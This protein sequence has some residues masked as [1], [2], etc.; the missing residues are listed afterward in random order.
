MN[1]G[2]QD[3]PD[4]TKEHHLSTYSIETED[5][6]AVHPDKDAD[7]REAGATGAAFATEEQLSEATTLW[8]DSSLVG[9]WNSFAGAPPF[10]ELKE[11]RR[12]RD[13]K[14]VVTKI[15]TAAQRPG[16]ALQEEMESVEV[17]MLRAQQGTLNPQKAAKPAKAAP[18]APA[19]PRATKNSTSRTAGMYPS[20]ARERARPQCSGFSSAT[21][22]PRRKRSWLRP[23][24]RQKLSVRS[25]I[26]TLGTKHGYT[27]ITTLS[28]TNKARVYAIVKQHVS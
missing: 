11:V 12:F 18:K 6:L 4:R 2:V 26:W 13:R 8:S 27:V 23:T 20:S 1:R 7:I 9:T 24:N 5:N 10:A 22:A 21:A 25:F 16:E 15:W 19:K 28:E 14:S 3:E 17:D